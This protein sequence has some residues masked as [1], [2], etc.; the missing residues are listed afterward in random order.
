M[1]NAA[2]GEEG[3]HRLGYHVL[4]V[5]EHSPAY[6]AGIRPF[7]DYI[8]AVNGIRLNEENSTI[9]EQMHASEEKILTMDVYSTRDQAGRRVEMTPTRKWGDGT[10]GLL[11]CSIRF[12]M[13][14]AI[15]DV[16]WH[17]LDVAAGSPAERSGLCP[18]TDY[19]IG[20]PYGIM[21]GEG[22][23]YDLVEDNIGEP[24]R[25]HVYNTDTDHVREIIIVP[26]EGWG[27]EGLLGCGVGYGYLHRLPR[28]GGTVDYDSSSARVMSFPYQAPHGDPSDQSHRSS[29][30]A[31]FQQGDMVFDQ[32]DNRPSD[33]SEH[34]RFQGQPLRFGK[35]ERPDSDNEP[36]SDDEY[37]PRRHTQPPRR[38][39]PQ[40]STAASMAQPA[41]ATHPHGESDHHY[42]SRQ[43][44]PHQH[45]HEQYPPEPQQQVTLGST[46]ASVEQVTDRTIENIVSQ[47]QQQQ[48]QQLQ[49]HLLQQDL[50]QQHHPAQ[51]EPHSITSHTSSFRDS[52]MPASISESG[53]HQQVKRY[54]NNILTSSR[55]PYGQLTED[56]VNEG[57]IPFGGTG[58]SRAGTAFN[59]DSQVMAQGQSSPSQPFQQNDQA[60]QQNIDIESNEEHQEQE[61]PVI[62]ARF[63]PQ[64]I[65]ARMM[66][67]PH[68]RRPG[69][70]GGRGR[71]GPDGF[72]HQGRISLAQ[73]QAQAQASDLYQQEMARATE[74]FGAMTSTSSEAEKQAEEGEEEE[75]EEKEK[76][77]ELEDEN[78]SKTKKA[79]L[80]N[81]NVEEE[82]PSLYTEN[83]ERRNSEVEMGPQ[84]GPKRKEDVK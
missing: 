38:Y 13:F 9:H 79:L 56:D 57:D 21:R 17:I 19:I 59:V 32:A 42:E 72:S 33:V 2:S 7:F 27:G 51:S 63:P 49:Q 67:S 12:C 73:V 58:N 69:S 35:G 74:T 61:T 43:Q 39:T 24:L 25:L 77:R 52:S 55:K 50:E 81:E 1:G 68:G 62:L 45:T 65:A 23:L 76:E 18:Y 28:L 6:L 64:A 26:H 47:Q 71:I 16:V 31:S 46:V 78:M 37:I 41:P 36:E 4:Q 8:V 80:P 29:L 15:N 66:Q 44:G 48:E 82:S 70:V 54:S 11:G 34:M 60:Q 5:K 53:T 20:T 75:E 10:G 40:E 84:A 14:D 22:D 83:K 30:P 3:R